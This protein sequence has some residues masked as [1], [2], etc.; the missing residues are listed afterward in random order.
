MSTS[1][2]PAAFSSHSPKAH[3]LTRHHR[4]RRPAR[5]RRPADPHHRRQAG[6]LRR[7]QP[8]LQPDQCLLPRRLP[9]RDDH[10]AHH[11]VDSHGAR[12]TFIHYVP[13]WVRHPGFLVLPAGTAWRT[14]HADAAALRASYQRTV[15][16]VGRGPTSSRS[17][18]TCHNA[19][20]RPPGGL[21]TCVSAAP[22]PQRIRHAGR[23][24]RRDGRR[25][26]VP[27]TFRTADPLAFSPGLSA[28]WSDSPG[29]SH[30][31]ASTDP[32]VTVSRY[33]ALAVL[34]C[35]QQHS[36]RLGELPGQ[37][38]RPPPA[39]AAGQL[40]RAR[41]LQPARGFPVRQA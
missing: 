10:P 30:P 39:A 21:V 14:D 23:P 25:G 15:A 29:E 26:G 7:R 20:K 17:P 36:Q 41:D 5:A 16:V 18:P 32:C 27:W 2:S 24:Q 9:G 28:Q 31:R 19:G 6:R 3:P 12:V 33:T 4:D 13:I 38:T 34:G 37:L 1:P 11:P 35:G 22:T 8:D 40:I